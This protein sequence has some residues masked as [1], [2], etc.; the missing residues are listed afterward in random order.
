MAQEEINLLNTDYEEKYGFRDPELY[1]KKIARGLSAGVIEEISDT[2]GEPD[3]MRKFRLKA[4]DVFFKKPMPKWGADLSGIDFD[5]MVYYLK[6]SERKST[7]W[8]DVPEAI[9]N[10]FDKLGIPEAEKKFLGGV[11]A[12]YES[13]TVYHKLRED[14]EAKGIVFLDTDTALK[15]HEGI[16]RKYFGT[17]V[18]MHDN[19]FAALNSACWSGGSFIYVPKNVR[20]DMPLQAYFRINARNMGQFE[21]TLIIADEGAS[22]N[23]VEGCTAPTYSTDSLHA[24]VVEL[25]ALKNA[26]IRYTT[27]Q[28]WSGNVYNLVTK[29]AHAYENA[30]V[31]WIDCNLGCLAGD[32]KIFLNSDIKSISDIEAED[33]VFAVDRNFELNRHKVNGKKYSGKQKVYRMRTL[34]HREIKA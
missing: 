31:E 14:L 15:E 11:G 24:A 5:S 16:F 23:Y 2:K 10:T 19:K 32:T 8:D 18:P 27:I 13:E 25:V 26:K 28:N 33:T 6:P 34:N 4:L 17:L 29:R 12:Q 21:R 30:V 20:V 1:V 7:S 22:V 9:K 3:W